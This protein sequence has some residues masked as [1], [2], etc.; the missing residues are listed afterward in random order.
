M[1][2]DFRKEMEQIRLTEKKKE[3][4][5][6]SLCRET[7]L[8]P[9]VEM[10]SVHDGQI[11]GQKKAV[12]LIGALFR[13]SSTEALEQLGDVY[14]DTEESWVYEGIRYTLNGYWY[15]RENGYAMAEI[16]I[17][18]VD[19]SPFLDWGEAYE[20]YGRMADEAG[21]FLQTRFSDAW[22]RSGA[23]S[24][25]YGSD[26]T[27]DCFLADSFVFGQDGQML[28][29][30]QLEL[31]TGKGQVV[32]TYQMEDTGALPIAVVRCPELL[33]GDRMEFSGAGFLLRLEEARRI[34]FELETLQVVLRDGTEYCYDV[35]ADD[36]QEEADQTGEA[37]WEKSG[38]LEYF[39][40]GK[41][42]FTSLGYMESLTVG[43]YCYSG[44]LEDYIDV[45][46]IASVTL[47]GVPCTIEVV[48]PEG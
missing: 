17:E 2:R 7:G 41:K 19:G 24:V 39:R 45:H 18:T 1:Y 44:T 28:E 13:G 47:N 5:W 25:V 33:G 46:E 12:R 22:Y 15:D 34:G 14:K 37:D 48:Q 16:G 10:V 6:Q 3:Q 11:P 4:M 21:V 9:A 23:V 42:N 29:N 40:E 8:D 30:F 27:A 32:G 38:E 43:L 35:H 26:H 31:V 36:R 20:T